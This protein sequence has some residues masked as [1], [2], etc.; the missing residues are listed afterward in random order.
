LYRDSSRSKYTLGAGFPKVFS[1]G[2]VKTIEQTSLGRASWLYTAGDNSEYLFMMGGQSVNPWIAKLD[3][4][5]LE[6][7]QFTRIKTGLYI[8]GLLIHGNGHVYAVQSN[9]LYRFWEGDLTNVTTTTLPTELTS[10][11]TNGMLVTRDGLLVIKQWT[12]SF[13][14][15]F[16]FYEMVTKFCSRLFLGLLIV[17]ATSNVIL[18]KKSNFTIPRVISRLAL[19]IPMACLVF[20]TIVLGLQYY[21]VRLLY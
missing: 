3:S 18:M 17:I 15:F 1:E 21:L 4:I 6:V 20:L 14:D 9:I 2:D 16:D 7:L 19:A 12:F 5:T 11:E 8:G 10:V 13:S